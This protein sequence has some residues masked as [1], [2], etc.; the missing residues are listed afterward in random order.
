MNS[1]L[2]SLANLLR[3][4]V[5]TAAVTCASSPSHQI[6]IKRVLGAC[7]APRPARQSTMLLSLQDL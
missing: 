7:E 6:P 1:T 2:Q 4:V 3:K 5:M